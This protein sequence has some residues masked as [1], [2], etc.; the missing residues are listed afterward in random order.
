[1]TE[2]LSS[3]DQLKGFFNFDS[4]PEYQ[5][6]H[7][8][9]KEV[10]FSVQRRYPEYSNFAPPKKRDG[11]PD[12]FALIRIR[13]SPEQVTN[14]NQNLVPISVAIG[15]HSRYILNHF[16]YDFTDD[17]CPTEESVLASKRTPR[18]LELIFLKDYFFDHKKNTFVDQNGKEIE[19]IEI[20]NHYYELH[21]ATIDKFKGKVL[22]WKMSSTGMCQ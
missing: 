15:T 16:D 12:T 20:L 1:M 17:D 9:S 10:G 4:S 19:G 18:P 7:S 2:Y 11:S 3:G 6:F 21:L 22:K 5:E 13:Y 8:F 14:E